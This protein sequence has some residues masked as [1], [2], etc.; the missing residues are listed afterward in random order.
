M[1][2]T[3]SLFSD[4][5]DKPVII[6]SGVFQAKKQSRFK[7]GTQLK[8]INTGNADCRLALEYYGED[9]KWHSILEKY[10]S[11]FKNKKRWITTSSTMPKNKILKSAVTLRYVIELNFKGNILIRKSTILKK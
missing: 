6:C 5:A 7:I 10:I 9:K 4:N 3:F 2:S 8:L 11:N 1:V